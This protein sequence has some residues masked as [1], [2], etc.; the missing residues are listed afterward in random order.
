MT[1]VLNL[2]AT[3]V[4][5]T[6]T[7]VPL[8]REYRTAEPLMKTDCRPLKAHYT[9]T[10]R[11]NRTRQCGWCKEWKPWAAFYRDESDATARRQHMCKA[12]QPP[13]RQSRK[14]GRVDG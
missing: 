7:P 1:R 5:E 12:C 4:S 8:S 10:N 2:E 14:E 3:T 6:W 11:T 9:T 13:Y